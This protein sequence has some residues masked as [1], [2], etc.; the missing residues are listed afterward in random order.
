MQL[1]YA[2]PE[3]KTKHEFIICFCLEAQLL[4]Y[5]K[6]LSLLQLSSMVK[7][8]TSQEINLMPL[9]AL[10]WLSQGLLSTS[11]KI[12]QASPNIDALCL[13]TLLLTTFSV[14]TC[15]T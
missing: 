9:L 8:K 7:T 14:P 3:A 15:C 2:K 11:V 5:S 12:L 4:I 10:K 1:S 6:S 13:Q